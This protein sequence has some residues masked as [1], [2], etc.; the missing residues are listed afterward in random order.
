MYEIF[1]SCYQA[2]YTNK[3]KI[4]H[5]LFYILFA[6]NNKQGEKIFVSVSKFYIYHLRRYM[7][8]LRF[9]FYEH[10]QVQCKKQEY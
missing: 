9:T 5:K 10:L 8:N 1:F 2:H 7:I 4:L 6:P 3:N